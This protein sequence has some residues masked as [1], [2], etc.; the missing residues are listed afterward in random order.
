[1]LSKFTNPRRKKKN[2]DQNVSPLAMP[3]PITTDFKFSYS[4]MW[5]IQN[6]NVGTSTAPFLITWKFL[7]DSIVVA[8]AATTAVQKFAQI[9]LKRVTLW[10]PAIQTSGTFVAQPCELDFTNTAGSLFAVPQ[11]HT[12]DVSL[13]SS[14]IACVS[15]KPPKGSPQANWQV[16]SAN[17]LLTM[18]L[19]IGGIIRIDFQAVEAIASLIAKSTAL[20]GATVG[21]QYI[22][23]LDGATAATTLFLPLGFQTA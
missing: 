16:S 6:S 2:T 15:K 20:V 13:G 23:G 7:F 14:E 1:M 17:N 11:L 5:V 10:T 4:V 12:V 19:P 8:T 18:V 3:S 9:K 22:C 21:Q